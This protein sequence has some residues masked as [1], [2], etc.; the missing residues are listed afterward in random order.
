MAAGN[1]PADFCSPFPTLPYNSPLP[2]LTL[3]LQNLVLQLPTLLQVRL[4]ES[5]MESWIIK[6]E[7]LV[8]GN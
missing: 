3:Q 1:F 4:M 5:L 8:V 6:E 2:N 7:G